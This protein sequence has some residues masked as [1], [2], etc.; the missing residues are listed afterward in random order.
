MTRSIV[1]IFRSLTPNTAVPSTLS[2]PIRLP[3]SLLSSSFRF[4]AI[5][6]SLRARRVRV[7]HIF[8]TLVPATSLVG[9][10]NFFGTAAT[11]LCSRIKE[12]RSRDSAMSA[13]FKDDTPPFLLEGAVQIALNYLERAGEIDDYTE[14]C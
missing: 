2:L 8:S 11:C 4:M 7:Q 3:N 6:V 1:P 9:A 13:W 5:F 12:E 10:P 14:T